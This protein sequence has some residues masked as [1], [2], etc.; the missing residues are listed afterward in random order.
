[1]GQLQQARILPAQA[2]LGYPQPADNGISLPGDT[3]LN[4]NARIT[5][6]MMLLLSAALAGC[7]S[8]GQSEPRARESDIAAIRQIAQAFQ[9][10]IVQKDKAAYLALFFSDNPQEVGWQAVVDDALLAKIQRE[11]P[12]AIKARRRP[13][14]HFIALI[15]S[16]VAS[17]TPEEESF[18]NL[19]IH[20]DGEI[21]SVMFDYVYRSNH[22]ATN[23]GEEHWQLVRT[24]SGW[25]I[26]SVVYTIREPLPRSSP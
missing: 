12:A 26:Y 22:I 5:S 10:A 3:I 8:L 21:G 9:T 11:R 16:V 13:D 1:M 25:K 7:A 14:N 17:P 2:V 4:V 23:W 15:D 24:E 6:P 19:K 20:T 18:A